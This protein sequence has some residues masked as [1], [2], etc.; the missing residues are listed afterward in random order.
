VFIHCIY[1]LPVYSFCVNIVDTMGWKRRPAA[2]KVCIALKP[3]QRFGFHNF[4]HSLANFL[5]SKGKDVKNDPGH[6]A[7]PSRAPRS[8]CIRK[9]WMNLNWRRRE[10]LLLRLPAVRR[11]LIKNS[12]PDRPS[13]QFRVFRLGLLQDGEVGVGVFPEGEEILIG[14]LGFGGVSLQDISA[15]KVEMR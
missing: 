6:F 14:H 8:T 10:T 15:R 9:R 5:I 1:I 13:L 7:M 2:I 3:R 12:R 11:R 4:R